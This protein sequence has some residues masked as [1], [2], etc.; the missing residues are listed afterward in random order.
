M[1]KKK[2]DF[3]HREAFKMLYLRGN[4]QFPNGLPIKEICKVLPIKKSLAY[5]L[6]KDLGLEEERNRI[7]EQVVK[8]SDSVEVQ[9][10]AELKRE[11]M[12]RLAG[13]HDLI[14]AKTM[15]AFTQAKG[16]D[17]I[18]KLLKAVKSSDILKDFQMLNG[19]PTE[20]KEIR[21]TVPKNWEELSYEEL[22]GKLSGSKD[23]IDA[24]YEVE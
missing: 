10:F 14:T 9:I 12:M 18:V 6:V 2:M 5:Q 8:I 15:S 7:N 20:T 11:K 13:L 19:D 4:D 21:H 3:H 23:A 17:D 1:A 24:D 16:I 22:K